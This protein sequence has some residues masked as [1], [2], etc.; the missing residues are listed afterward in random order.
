MQKRL[1]DMAL[2]PIGDTREQL[3]AYLKSELAKWAVAVKLSGAK[4]E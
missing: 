3:G 1:N 2:T 4:V